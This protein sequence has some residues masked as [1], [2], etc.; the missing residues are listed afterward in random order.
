MSDTPPNPLDGLLSEF[1]LGPA[2]ARAKSEPVE[3]KFKGAA[4]REYKP[5][6]G[7]DRRDD[8]RGG[9]RGNR[10]DRRDDRRGGQGGGQGGG[11]RGRNFDKGDRGR[12][13]FH[14][15]EIAP[16]EGVT[17]SLIPEKA[18]IQLIIKEVHQVA[19][20][21]PLFDIAQIILAERAR[22]RAVFE[23]SEKKDPFYRC[24]LEEAIYLTKEEALRHLLEAPWRDRFIEESTIEIDP[25]K[26]NFQSVARCGISGEWLGP[27]NFH[28]YQTEI[29]RIHRERF[30]NMPFESYLGKVRTERG[31]EAVNAWLDSMKIQTRWRILSDEEITARRTAA[32]SKDADKSSAEPSPSDAPKAE[33]PAPEEP[34]E[35]SEAVSEPAASDAPVSETPP[36]EPT[37]TEETTDTPTES[38]SSTEV[39]SET[40]DEAPEASEEAPD[41]PAEPEPAPEHKWFTDRAEFERSLVTDVLQKAFHVTRK[42][43]VSAAITG[44]NLSPGLLVRLKGTGNHHHKHPAIIIPLVCKILETEHMPVF[45]RKGKLYTG[46]ARPHALAADAVLAPRPAEM[47]KWIRENT[48]AKLEGLWKAVLPEGSTAPPAEYAADLFWLLQ[49]GHILL[50]TD[51]TLVV[52]EVPKPQQPK[53]KKAKKEAKPRPEPK[54]ASATE[55]TPAES[56]P[57]T[58]KDTL[59]EPTP[60]PANPDSP[61][62][63]ESDAPPTEPTSQESPPA[64]SDA[65]PA[66]PQPESSATPAPAETEP[67]PTEP[68]EPT[69]PSKKPSADL[70]EK[71]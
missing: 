52:Q 14:R 54:A 8:S 41:S 59:P 24:K 68:T 37:A 64:V 70:P 44:K 66:E 7:G 43:K 46:P 11:G 25:P 62:P 15:E 31:E 30:S 33:E 60:E 10:D 17:L 47:V 57:A 2:W 69:E 49:Q 3:K 35:G 9:G 56:I 34:A 26:G 45:K 20:V 71:S 51:D 5:R 23:I 19:R 4:E 21:Y 29:R 38:E 13:D 40:T 58:T 39:A 61:H 28:T 22:N 16:A 53:K 18:A 50:Y 32:E 55:A 27:P 12:P 63:S 42:A 65:S 6:R 67:T 36:Q 48:P 1:S